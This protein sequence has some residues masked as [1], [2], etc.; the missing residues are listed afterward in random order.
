MK[1]SPTLCTLSITEVQSRFAHWRQ[2]KERREQIPEDLWSAAVMLCEQY[3]VH[4]VSRALRLHH[5]SL[6]DRVLAG[7]TRQPPI[8]AP[9]QDFITIDM[10]QSHIAEYTIELEHRN[11]NR[12]R[13][14][15]KGQADLDLH[16]FAESFWSRT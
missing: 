9:G 15:C 16:A 14:H 12:M 4:R 2:T 13:M 11:G 7:Q 6:R 1:N 10:V 5:S 8:T 3:S